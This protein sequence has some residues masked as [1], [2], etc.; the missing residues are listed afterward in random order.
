M[1]A[2]FFAFFVGVLVFL[3]LF[4]VRMCVHLCLIGHMTMIVVFA[5]GAFAGI[6]K[7]QH[8]SEYI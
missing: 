4:V 2:L 3:C 6:G 7:K 1:N 5:L 8:Q